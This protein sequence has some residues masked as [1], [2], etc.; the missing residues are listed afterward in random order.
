LARNKY[1]KNL[2]EQKCAKFGAISDNFR[3]SPQISLKQIEKLKIGKTRDQIQP[4]V[5]VGGL[6]EKNGE[7]WSS[8][9][10]L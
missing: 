8:N 7:L 4:L 1:P 5:N 2:R 3:V 10:N 6:S 9:R